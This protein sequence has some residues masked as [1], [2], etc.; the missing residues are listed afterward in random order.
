MSCTPPLEH[1][2]TSELGWNPCSFTHCFSFSATTNQQRFL[3]SLSGQCQPF[4]IIALTRS[5]T[6]TGTHW[7][8]WQKTLW[9][10]FGLAC[11]KNG[12]SFRLLHVKQTPWRPWFEELT[13]VKSMCLYSFQESWDWAWK[14]N[15]HTLQPTPQKYYYS[16]IL[17][18][19]KQ[20]FCDIQSCNTSENKPTFNL[21]WFV[22]LH[23]QGFNITRKTKKV[24]ML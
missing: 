8:I 13:E 1:L 23:A 18:S 12:F 7:M 11:Y 14:E 5:H 2:G 6:I 15:V 3:F 24:L 22:W 4:C 17:S 21:S 19:A 9:G 16:R 10:I 20:N